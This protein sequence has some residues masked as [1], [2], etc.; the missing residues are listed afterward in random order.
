MT[1]TA[2]SKERRRKQREQHGDAVCGRCG[3]L[4]KV[5]W[6]EA[7]VLRATTCQRFVP[8]VGRPL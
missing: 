8:K 7:P 4:G 1:Y 5:H 3:Q 6:A 2:R